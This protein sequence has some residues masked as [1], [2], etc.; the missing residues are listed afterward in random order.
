MKHTKTFIEN[1]E[2]KKKNQLWNR[3]LCF[4]GPNFLQRNK[5][6]P[7]GPLN[8]SFLSLSRSLSS[9]PPPTHT[10]THAYTRAGSTAALNP[11]PTPLALFL[12][13]QWKLSQF[14]SIHAYILAWTTPLYINNP[15]PHT[16]THPASQ[17]LL[18]PV[19]W[20]PPLSKLWSLKAVSCLIVALTQRLNS[21]FN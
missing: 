4:H 5:G 17:P 3:F 14:S 2:R 16:H 19:K 11:T 10:R 8:P 18:Y 6:S 13:P 9:P 12:I 15:P 1:V 21:H 20:I 7:L